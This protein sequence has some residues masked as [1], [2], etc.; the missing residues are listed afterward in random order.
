[1][2]AGLGRQGTHRP[3]GA[4]FVAG[5]GSAGGQ[6]ANLATLEN[7]GNLGNLGNLLC[8]TC[9]PILCG[10]VLCR[11][12]HEEVIK[13]DQDFGLAYSGQPTCSSSQALALLSPDVYICHCSMLNMPVC[14][15]PV[16]ALP[17]P[18]LRPQACCATAPAGCVL[19]GAPTPSSSTR[20]RQSGLRV[21]WLRRLGK[22]ALA[23]V[24]VDLLTPHLHAPAV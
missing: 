11:A 14:G 7:L 4:P 16:C 10:C 19:C 13:L 2:Q 6:H 21:R 1:M 24:L 8:C 17:R 3:G 9:V 12:V 5:K 22:L 18:L 23:A 15:L 20:R